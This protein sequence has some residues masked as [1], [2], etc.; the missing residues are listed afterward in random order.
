MTSPIPTVGEIAPKTDVV[1][2][3]AGDEMILLDLETGVYFTLNAVGAAI[4]KG[5]EAG[6]DSSVILAA[7]VD[8]FEVDEDT[9]KADIGEYLDAL[10]AEGLVLRK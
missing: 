8:Q 2:R 7:V 3:A 9:A 6:S 5:L 4:W 1:A 10:A